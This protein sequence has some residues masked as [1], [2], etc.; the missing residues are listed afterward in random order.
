MDLLDKLNEVIKRAKEPYPP[1]WE[2]GDEIPI[3]CN[4]AVVIVG[5]RDDGKTFSVNVIPGKPD[6]M[7]IDLDLLEKDT[8]PNP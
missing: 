2:P 1:P 4:D 8:A 3:V 5:L 6:F 7:D